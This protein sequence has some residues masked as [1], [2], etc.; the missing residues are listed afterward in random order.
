VY[1]TSKS[2]VMVYRV[3]GNGFHIIDVRRIHV[4]FLILRFMADNS[5]FL[6]ALLCADDLNSHV[7]SHLSEIK[8]QI[9]EVFL[10]LSLL[11]S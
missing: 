1:R 3:S 6:L 4:Y 2:D 9:V 8:I 10:S 7:T 11:L 5:H